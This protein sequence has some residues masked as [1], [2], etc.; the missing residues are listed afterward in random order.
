MVPHVEIVFEATGHCG[1]NGHVIERRPAMKRRE[2][3]IIE[4]DFDH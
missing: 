3:I 2:L 4:I 1:A